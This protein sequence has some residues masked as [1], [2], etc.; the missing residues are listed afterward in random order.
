MQCPRCQC[1]NQE[2]ARF[3][4]ECGTVLL[5]VCSRC[6][7]EVSPCAKFCAKC[8]QRLSAVSSP[9]RFA[10]PLS[11]TPKHLTD[12]ILTSRSALLRASKRMSKGRDFIVSS[13]VVE[14]CLLEV[15]PDNFIC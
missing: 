8:G 9:F 6:H 15:Q 3:C 10:S 1:D 14:D 5:R 2:A 11:P 7:H 12:K 4:E 13:N